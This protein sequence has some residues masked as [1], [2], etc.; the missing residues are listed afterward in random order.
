MFVCFQI[1]NEPQGLRL[2]NIFMAIEIT[3]RLCNGRTLDRL[4]CDHRVSG[5]IEGRTQSLRIYRHP[6][7]FVIHQFLGGQPNQ[8]E[9]GC[10]EFRICFAP[11]FLAVL[12]Y[13]LCVCTI[14]AQCRYGDRYSDWA[15][16]ICCICRRSE[17]P[18]PFLQGIIWPKVS[19]PNRPVGQATV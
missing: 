19:F 2:V 12:V 7:F 13:E 8:I 1:K 17:G 14:A 10:L 18:S 5:Q 11:N 15:S 9:T 6:L 4:I 16:S 3:R